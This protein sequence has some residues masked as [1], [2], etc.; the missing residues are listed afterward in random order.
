MYLGLDLG[1]TNVKSLVVDDEGRI[2]GIGS[3]PVDRFCTPDGGVE[4]DI[5]QIWTST[6]LAIRQAVEGVEGGAVE[7]IGISSQGGA[8]QWLDGQDRPLGRVISWLDQRGRAGDLEFAAR[9]GNAFLGQHVGHGASAMTIGQVL[10]VRRQSPRL[11][12]APNRLGFVGDVIVGRLCGRRAH[13]ATSLGIAMLYNPW[14]N[15]AD[16]EV[17]AALGLQESQLPDLLPATAAAGSLRPQLAGQLGL[18]PG[19]PVSPA[20][21]DQYAAALGAGAV[22]PGDVNFG[23]GTAWVLLAN[24]QRLAPPI[25]PSAF[26]CSHPVTGL[27]GQMLSLSN[28]GS[29]IEWA[30]RLVGRERSSLK[31]VDDL[32]ETVPPGSDGLRFWPLLVTTPEGDPTHRPGGRLEGINLAHQPAHLMRSVVEGLACELA[33]HLRFLTAAGFTACQLSMCGS[34]AASRLTPQIL[35]DVTG[36]PVACVEVSD[37]SAFG[38]AAIA[39]ALADHRCLLA[40]VSRRWAPASRPIPPGPQRPVYRELFREYLAAFGVASE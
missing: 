24:T 14:L 17:L 18:R 35:A 15:R 37:V 31:E 33:R 4:Q 32:I 5:E 30:M 23:A 22:Q 29:A 19:I 39:C 2:Q 36:L 28:G 1:T 12:E 20:I 9:F 25:V 6:C 34:A 3:A 40:E 27:Y 10:R 11:I 8:L 16:P 26:V 21:H 38:A 7:A 13:D